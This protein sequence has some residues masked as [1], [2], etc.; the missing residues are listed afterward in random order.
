MPSHALKSS[1]DLSQFV[2]IGARALQPNTPPF[3]ARMDSA[4][5]EDG[6]WSSEKTLVGEDHTIGP[7]GGNHIDT[8]N[9][10]IYA[11][12][13]GGC[14]WVNGG[15]NYSGIKAYDQASQIN[16]SAGLSPSESAYGHSSWV[17]IS[18]SG[19]SNQWNGDIMDATVLAGFFSPRRR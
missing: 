14:S 2:Q 17:N 6:S 5:S 8:D 11:E 4:G 1:A 15:R 16:G 10:Q 9:T 18:A 13:S 19:R 7:S 12:E 3:N